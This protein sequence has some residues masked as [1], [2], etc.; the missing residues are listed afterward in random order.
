LVKSKE[1][2]PSKDVTHPVAAGAQAFSKLFIDDVKARKLE[3][4]ELFK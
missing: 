4:A 2:E 1:G 3:I